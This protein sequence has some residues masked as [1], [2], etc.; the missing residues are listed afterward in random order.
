MQ[1]NKII[2]VTI[3]SLLLLLSLFAVTHLL[4]AREEIR[5]VILGIG[6]FLVLLLTLWSKLPMDAK[7]LFIL[8]LGFSIGGKGFAYLSPAEPIYIGEICLLF[9]LCGMVVRLRNVDFLSSLLHKLLLIY[10]IY[11]A[12]HLIVDY[13]Q[14][15]LLAIRDSSMAY[16]C[17]FFFAAYSLFCN[18]RI[19]LAFEKIIKLA[20]VCSVIQMIYATLWWAMGLPLF[21]GFQPHPDAYI[22]LNVAAVFYF[23]VKGIESKNA[24]LLGLA[25]VITISVMAGKTSALLSLVAVIVGAI[26][27]GR[28]KG[29]V[30]IAIVMIGLGIIAASLLI[31]INPDMIADKIAGS[32]TIESFGIQDGQFVG[33]SEASGTTTKWR[34]DWWMT[35][36]HD[37]ME[38]APFWGQ[39]FGADITGPFLEAWLGPAYADATGYARFPHSVIF[40][41]I[42]RIG[43]IGLAIFIPILTAITLL[44]LKSSRKFFTSNTRRD[45]DLICY[46]VVLAGLVNGIL[47]A[48]YEVPYGAVT[49]WV[50]L[51]YLAS[52][53]YN[54]MTMEVKR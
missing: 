53:Y 34:W 40:T 2:Q 29:L 3:V 50:C 44:T 13:E 11:A 43:I 14:Y 9:C 12:I 42:G 26:I 20:M 38:M 21:P 6:F 48:T 35:I 31:F 51:A 46:A 17:L 30:V 36:W 18:E 54:P 28:I 7:L 25:A 41:V 45:A 52:R 16:Y 15:R 22:A 5:N 49:H 32:D 33:F 4:E 23:L 24:L 19:T 10:L 39:G 37:T 8:I 1:N 27:F 47:Q